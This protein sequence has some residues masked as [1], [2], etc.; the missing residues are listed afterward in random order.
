M[1]KN[2]LEMN[3]LRYGNHDYDVNE[4]PGMIVDLIDPGSKVLDVGC[5]DGSLARLMIQKKA[6]TVLGIEPN[7]VRAKAAGETGLFVI[8]SDFNQQALPP[9][10][11]FDVIVF[12][13]VLEHMVHPPDALILAKKYLR[14]EGFV[15]ASIPN[16]AHWTVRLNLLKGN[17]N[18]SEI[19]IMD[20]S[21]VRWFTAKTL[22]SLFEDCGYVVDSL[23]G[24]SGTWM[25]EY[26]ST[27]PW[28]WLSEN[29]KKAIIQFMTNKFSGLFS[30]QYVIKA[31]PIK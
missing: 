26:K 5:G 2:T 10:S 9:D 23:Q 31:V 28:K 24:A 3:P 21:H 18:Y 25:H 1:L 13:D 7:L 30:S 20:A 15:I 4:S 17:F 19:G 11:L 8:N 16:V 14:R 29:G 27:L 6:A 22:V 12:A